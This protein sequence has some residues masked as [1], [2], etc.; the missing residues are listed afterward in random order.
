MRKF[1]FLAIILLCVS[2]CACRSDSKPQMATVEN[3]F[4]ITSVELPES[5]GTINDKMIQF[6]DRIGVI[7]NDGYEKGREYDTVLF[8]VK[9]DGSD[10]QSMV[11]PRVRKESQIMGY[12]PS[13]DGGCYILDHCWAGGDEPYGKLYRYNADMELMFEVDVS[14]YGSLNTYA[15]DFTLGSNGNCYIT[16]GSTAVVLDP[17]G[18]LIY[19]VEYDEMF[20]RIRT[21]DRIQAMDDGRV[22]IVFYNQKY[23]ESEVGYFDDAGKTIVNIK[24]RRIVSANRIFPGNDGYELFVTNSLGVYGYMAS[25]YE[26]TELCSWINSDIT[27]SDINLIHVISP[28]K[29]A[30]HSHDSLETADTEC[31]TLNILTRISDN[32]VTSKKLITFQTFGMHEH[33][34]RGVVAFNKQSSEYRVV[35]RDYAMYNT[36]GDK[37]QS[38]MHLDKDIASGEYIPDVFSVNTTIYE[39]YSQIGLFCDLYDF[40]DKDTEMTR[41]SFVPCVLGPLETNGHLYRLARGFSF[42]TMSTT[43]DFPFDREDWTLEEMLDYAESVDYTLFSRYSREILIDYFFNYGMDNFIDSESNTCHFDNKTAKRLVKLI[44]RYGYGEYTGI[45]DKDRPE[46]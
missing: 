15:Q 28:D 7:C 19:T 8:S 44:D 13:S 34:M 26:E 10:P 24:K 31:E 36:V 41:E 23:G 39:K 32:I 33:I 18:Q 22:M 20:D 12:A 14:Q 46:Y 2:F 9:T 17:Q 45:S 1:T 5:Y 42:H 37:S 38:V 16:V 11:L 40:M 21:F 30:V 4:E 35:V 29:I 43:T 25:D 6:D 3:V 27:A